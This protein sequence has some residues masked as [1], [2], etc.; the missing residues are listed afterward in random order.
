MSEAE[1][2]TGEWVSVDLGDD[3]TAECRVAP[4]RSRVRIIELHVRHAQEVP[5]GQLDITRLRRLT[6]RNV[7]EA[8]AREYARKYE[9]DEKRTHL[10]ASA[11][12]LSRQYLLAFVAAAY[13]KAYRV[14]PRTAPRDVWR[15]LTNEFERGNPTV[16]RQYE[17]TGVRTLID[18]T[19]NV[20]WRRRYDDE[21]QESVPTLIGGSL[22]ETFKLAAGYASSFDWERLG[23]TLE[24]WEW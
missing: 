15:F 14:A 13:V 24:D 17:R 1:L 22:E 18:R 5:D 21:L 3:W 8:V 10:P 20:Y 2:A 23:D 7:G 9:A 19:E 11:G 4:H 16:F 6:K 12:D